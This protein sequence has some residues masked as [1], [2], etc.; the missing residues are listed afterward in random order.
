MIPD[1]LR[2]R[3][4]A[5]G[6]TVAALSQIAGLGAAAT[7]ALA[8][9]LL[10]LSSGPLPW[11]RLLHLEGFVL[12]LF[13]SLP[14][15]VPGTP[16]FSLGPL[17]ASEEGLMRAATIAG[18][19]SASVL[20][21]SALLAGVEPARLGAALRALHVPERLVRLFVTTARHVGLVG[22]EAH[23]LAE[24]MRARGFRPRS[25]RHTFR[26]LGYFIGML[27]VRALA[28]AERVE[29]A[30][31]CRGYEGRF[32][33]PALAPPRPGDWLFLTAIVGGAVALLA[34]DRL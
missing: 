20:L 25:N 17:T 1:D 3:L 5:A 8:A 16:L 9:L 27:L 32:P 7:A 21:V 24:A 11:R 10:A 6:S 13:V 22:E 34:A 4:L 14:F 33:R 15:T 2:I 23:R 29:E 18:K 12:L 28:R 26:S 19:V 30:M 31:L